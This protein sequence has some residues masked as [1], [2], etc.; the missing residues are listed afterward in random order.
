MPT[1]RYGVLL[2]VVAVVARYALLSVPLV[3][4]SLIH[5]LAGREGRHRCHPWIPP[6]WGSRW[7]GEGWVRGEDPEGR[8]GKEG[9]SRKHSISSRITLATGDKVYCRSGAMV[10][11]WCWWCC[12]CGG[13]LLARTLLAQD[14]CVGWCVMVISETP[15]SLFSVVALAANSE[16]RSTGTGKVSSED[17]TVIGE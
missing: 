4:S 1:V 16:Y 12:C 8:E 14:W 7:R 6:N 15:G 17:K 9:G 3:G 2:V 11:W 10:L 13:G 5:R